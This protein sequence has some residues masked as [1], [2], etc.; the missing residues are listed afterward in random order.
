MNKNWKVFFLDARHS[1]GSFDWFVIS[2]FRGYSL[3][4]G[5]EGGRVESLSFKPRLC[6]DYLA[7]NAHGK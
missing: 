7:L 2:D 6:V 1:Y 4:E 3:G 5:V